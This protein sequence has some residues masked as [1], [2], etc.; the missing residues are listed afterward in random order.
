MLGGPTASRVLQGR[1]EMIAQADAE[2]LSLIAVSSLP[3]QPLSLDKYSQ[4]YYNKTYINLKSNYY[5]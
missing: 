2:G 1:Q 4:L 3:H 5:F